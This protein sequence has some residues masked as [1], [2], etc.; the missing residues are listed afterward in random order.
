MYIGG[1]FNSNGALSPKNRA[2]AFVGVK[3]WGGEGD[4]P[5]GESGG[6]GVGRVVHKY[7][8]RT[9]LRRWGE[10]IGHKTR[11]GGLNQSGPLAPPRYR[12]IGLFR[13]DFP[14][15]AHYSVFHFSS[16]CQSYPQPFFF[17]FLRINVLYKFT[18]KEK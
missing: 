18:I 8:V 12:W 7:E 10:V 3:I 15:I 6:A 16:Q 2:N 4:A 13:K 9:S 14:L 5:R 1:V 17:P 11:Q